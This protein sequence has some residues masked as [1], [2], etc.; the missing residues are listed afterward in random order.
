MGRADK[1]LILRDF[2]GK[3]SRWHQV[4]HNFCGK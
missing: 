1:A 4:I 2:V 3:R